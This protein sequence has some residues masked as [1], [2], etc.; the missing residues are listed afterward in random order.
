MLATFHGVFQVLKWLPGIG[1][2]YTGESR[3]SGVLDTREL[4]MP[5][6]PDIGDSWFSPV[7][8]IPGSQE[9]PVSGIPRIPRFLVVPDTR[10]SG[11]VDCFFFSF[12]LQ[13]NSTAFKT[14]IYKKVWIPY[15]L[16][17]AYT[18]DS[19]SKKNPFF[20]TS[21]SAPSVPD[22]GESF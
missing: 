10:E 12:K 11:I 13:T 7:A 21:I 9:S 6:V 17:C 15:L 20:I 18:L 4:R 5:G 16:Y 22:T 8:G 1:Y 14:T 3:I 19:C 2:R